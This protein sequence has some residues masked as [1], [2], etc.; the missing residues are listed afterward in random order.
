[1]SLLHIYLILIK[2]IGVFNSTY[3]SLLQGEDKIDRGDH[4]NHI[5]ICI[6]ISLRLIPAISARDLPWTHPG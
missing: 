3:M 6:C 1:M 4:S 5:Y 2:D